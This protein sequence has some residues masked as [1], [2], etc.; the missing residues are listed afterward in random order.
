[1]RYKSPVGM[2]FG[3]WTILEDILEPDGRVGDGHQVMAQCSCGKIYKRYLSALR[4]RQSQRCE[5]CAM[6]L[7]SKR[8]VERVYNSV[9]RHI[10]ERYRNWIL[11]FRLYN[12]SR[13]Y[14]IVRCDCGDMKPMNYRDFLRGENRPFPGCNACTEKVYSITRKPKKE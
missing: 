11:V 8:N 4:A 9:D 12:G 2:V 14:Y 3:H 6:R 5:T 13:D 10:G 1:V 7:V